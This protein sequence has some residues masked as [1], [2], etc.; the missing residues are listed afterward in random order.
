M[1]VCVAEKPSVAGDIA[2]VLGARERKDGYFEGSGY[3]VT[4]TFGHLCQLWEP[5]RYYPAWKQWNLDVLPMIPP[6]YEIELI[7]DGGISKQFKV[8]KQLYKNAEYIVNCGDAGQEG[9]LIQRWVMRLAGVRCPVKRLWISSLTEE[10][11]RD[12][13]R[14]LQPQSNYDSLYEAGE[15]RAE[16][17]WLLGMN[18]TV[19]YTKKFAGYGQVLSVGRVQTPT[20]AMIVER[21]FQID[22]F[23]PEPYWVLSTK[24]RGTVF[25]CTKARFDKKSEVEN[26]LEAAKRNKLFIKDVVNRRGSEAPPQLYDLTSLQV[27]CNRKYGMSA[28][29]TLNTIQSLYEKK[30]T[31]YPRVDTKYLTEDIYMKCPEILKGLKGYESLTM[32]L[33]GK[34]LN[35]S[36]KV[37]DD[38]KVTDH[39]AI[40]PTGKSGDVNSLNDY[41]RKVYDLVCRRF[42]SVFY[43]AFEYNQTTVSANA[44]GVDFKAT[45]RTVIAEGWRVVYANVQKDEE[46]E[47]KDRDPGENTILP[48]FSVNESGK[49]DPSV[50]QKMT[51]PPARYNEASLLLA[52][53]TAGKLVEDETLR[54]AMKE[55]G[56][57]RPSSRASIIVK[58]LKRGY[59]IRDKKKLVST[60]AGRD[61]IHIIEA[62]M[63]KS[64]E[65]T[66]KWEKKLRDIEHGNYSRES[67][68]SELQE[69]LKEIIKA[70]KEDKS[71]RRISNQPSS[72]PVERKDYK[73]S[74]KKKYTKSPSKK[75]SAKITYS[76]VSVKEGDKCPICGKGTVRKGPYGLY[77]S[78]Y[79]QT[80]CRLKNK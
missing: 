29:T 40:I 1:I 63:L 38:S 44:G 47:N 53:E 70:V 76:S 23:L 43:P 24:Y 73:S 2:K 77:C 66:G 20:L 25:I 42:I 8:I 58:L 49:H 11:I 46:D 64:P 22:H 69:Q 12:G 48:S 65:L 51:T 35:R 55:N 14:H 37:F 45:G 21:D 9:E 61:L 3:Q 52:M 18:A 7:H 67:F 74:G 28:D 62:R 56:I 5:E 36:R 15:A 39:H 6:R 27:Q 68:M 19:L 60:Q 34:P 26:Y 75:S 31:T 13:F 10:S 59:I 32:L 72:S 16:G 17:D 79:R 57:G 54:D 4:W 80:G 78:E 50:Q 71:G 41:E 30:L 33:D